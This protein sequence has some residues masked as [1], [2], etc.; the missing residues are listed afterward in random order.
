MQGKDGSNDCIFMDILVP[1]SGEEASWNALEQALIL[2]RCPG[3]QINGLNV[4]MNGEASDSDAAQEIKR[5][6]EQRCREA[7]VQGVLSFA[8][9]EIARLV[10]DR[11]PYNDLVVLNIAHPPGSQFLSR[12]GS[13]L[14]TIIRRSA[15]PILAVPGMTSPMDR[16]L[17]AYDGSLKAN[18]ALFLAA[19]FA[20]KLGT[21]LTVLTVIETGKTNAKTLQHA[22]SYLE[23]REIQAG[24]LSDT[25]PADEAILK[26]AKD[27]SSNFILMGGYGFSPVVE[28]VLGSTLDRVL[29]EAGAPILICQ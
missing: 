7:G 26:A 16:L 14:R 10:I 13:G 1:L 29:R 4:L 12:L 17:L 3:T 23:A 6:F 15:R 22:R 18:E 24:Y 2:P 28:A 8:S 21:A 20:G 19:Y 11:M 9:G 27:Q 5:R 25:G